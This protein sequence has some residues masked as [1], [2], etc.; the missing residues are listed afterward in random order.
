MLILGNLSVNPLTQK[1]YTAS[2]HWLR[3]SVGKDNISNNTDISSG[4]TFVIQIAGLRVKT[5]NWEATFCISFY[6]ASW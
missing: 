4:K 6:R 1:Y 3:S 5:F 2:S